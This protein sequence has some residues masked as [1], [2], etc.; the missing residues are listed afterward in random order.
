MQGDVHPVQ[1]AQQVLAAYWRCWPG[2]CARQ[3]RCA[4]DPVTASR[5]GACGQDERG[6]GVADVL[7]VVAEHSEDVLEGVVGGIQDTGQ[8]IGVVKARAGRGDA[9]HGPVSWSWWSLLATGG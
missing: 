1:V 8:V 7:L 3:G 9:V 2:G 6:E 4:G 5:G